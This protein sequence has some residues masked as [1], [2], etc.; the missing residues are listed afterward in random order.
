MGCELDCT[1][2][3]QVVTEIVCPRSGD[4]E[5]GFEFSCTPEAWEVTEIERP[6]LGV[7]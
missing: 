4:P 7:A 6:R 3:A 1:P 2:E 5:V